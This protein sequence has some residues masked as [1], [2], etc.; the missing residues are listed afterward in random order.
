MRQEKKKFICW[1]E[2]VK[3]L[4]HVICNIMFYA[5]TGA[6]IPLWVVRIREKELF[7]L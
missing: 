4:S 7:P 5:G 2:Q 3:G 1:P 6:Q